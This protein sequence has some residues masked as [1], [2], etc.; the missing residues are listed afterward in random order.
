MNCFT[1]KAVISTSDLKNKARYFEGT[2]KWY[3]TTDYIKAV[4]LAAEERIRRTIQESE[5]VDA[6]KLLQPQQGNDV[7]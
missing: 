6:S 2:G 5:V 3:C 7:Y 4:D 1:C